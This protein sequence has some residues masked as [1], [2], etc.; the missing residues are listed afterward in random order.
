[1]SRSC[2]PPSSRS[3]SRRS[4]RPLPSSA[5]SYRSRGAAEV[6]NCAVARFRRCPANG[7]AGFLSPASR[8]ALLTALL[9]MY[10]LLA[11]AAGFAAVYLWG[12]VNRRSVFRRDTTASSLCSVHSSGSNVHVVT[13]DELL[14]CEICDVHLSYLVY[15]VLLHREVYGAERRYTGQGMLCMASTVAHVEA[16]SE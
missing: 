2:R 10:L 1:M 13:H 6:L 5:G 12:L 7:A 8:G 3:S 11:V 15:L 16:A 9:V 14:P 4:A